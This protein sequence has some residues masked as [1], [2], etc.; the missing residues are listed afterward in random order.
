LDF[1]QGKDN[2]LEKEVVENSLDP[3]S[4]SKGHGNMAD[5]RYIAGTKH[6]S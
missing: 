6:G 2:G 5:W 1:A 3:E 4:W